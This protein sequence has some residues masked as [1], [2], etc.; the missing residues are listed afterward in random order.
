MSTRVRKKKEEAPSGGVPRWLLGVVPL[1][2]LGALLFAF[3]R[4][5]PLSSVRGEFPPVEELTIERAVLESDPQAIV[6][7]VRN[8]G[9]DPVTIAQVLVDE[10]Y[11][12]FT[13]EPDAKVDRLSSAT[14]RVAYP[15]VEGEAHEVVLLSETG[16]P[17]A[18]EIAVAVETPKTTGGTLWTFTLLGLFVGVIPVALGLT[19]LPFV[20]R[21]PDQW[22]RFLLALTAGL[23]VFLAVDALDEALEASEG[24]AGAFQGVGLIVIGVV[25]A[26]AALYALDGWMRQRRKGDLSPYY[27][28]LLISVG[29]GL[30]NLGEGLAIGA[31]YSLG[32]VGLTAFLVLGFTLHNV[33][34]GLGIVTP[35]ARAKPSLLQLAGLGVIAGAPTIIGTW[36]GGL[37]YSPLLAV[38]F[39]AVGAGA[40][41]QVV[42]EIGKL[43]GR[44]GKP[45]S[46]PLNTIGFAAGVLIMYL[47]GLAVT[48]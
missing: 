19:W 22:V 7:T 3:I 1:I 11:W 21:L 43:L 9:P 29:I 25:V 15:W 27:I 41:V 31:A 47:T 48:A 5:D 39:L 45:L 40:I 26:L 32:E 14:V 42:W 20:R 44:D 46:A 4:I 36:S 6:L 17:F 12:N 37:A 24:V 30:H 18:H 38:L 13:I 16:V 35:L 8:G 23:L 34:E 28:A 10:A 33:T 2:A